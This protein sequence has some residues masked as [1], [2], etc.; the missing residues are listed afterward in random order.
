[1][2]AEALHLLVGRASGADGDSDRAGESRARHLAV[3]LDG[4]EPRAQEI[5]WTPEC[6]ACGGGATEM[7]FS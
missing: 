7:V 2:A 5:P 6:F 1:M 4:G 3:P